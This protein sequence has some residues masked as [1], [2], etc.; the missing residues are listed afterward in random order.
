MVRERK[1]GEW[2]EREREGV[3]VSEILHTILLP[4]LYVWLLIV[5]TLIVVV[6]TSVSIP[7]MQAKTRVKLNF[8]DH[9]AKFWELQVSLC[10]CVCVRACT[11][12]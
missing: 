8:L 3:R 11:Y 5:H 12:V 4:G 2:R 6:Y 10:V 9:L 7:R 1:R